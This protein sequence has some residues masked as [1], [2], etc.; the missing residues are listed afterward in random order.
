MLLFQDDGDNDYAWKEIAMEKVLNALDAGLTALNVMTA[1][2]M[3]KE[4]FIEDV[5]DR[6]VLMTKT[7]LVQS[8]YPEFDPVY[9]V[10]PSNKSMLWLFI[11]TSCIISI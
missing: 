7:Q 6:L 1:T 9:R 11:V 2:G 8:I 5:I 10:D 3:P 4:V